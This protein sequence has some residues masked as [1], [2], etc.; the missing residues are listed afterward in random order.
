MRRVET[1]SLHRAVT[2]SS[3]TF[4]PVSPQS[5]KLASLLQAIPTPPPIQDIELIGLP[6][7]CEFCIPEVQLLAS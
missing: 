2:G 3:H 5:D 1:R 6:H 7:C 4:L